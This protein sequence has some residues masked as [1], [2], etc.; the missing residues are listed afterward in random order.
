MRWLPKGYGG[1]RRSAEEIKREGW[2]EQGLLVVSAE[3]QRLT[4]PERELIRQL[5]ERLYGRR[6]SHEA[7]H[8]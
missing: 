7:R 8:G 5:G 4:W 2:H 6:A 3:D 1:E